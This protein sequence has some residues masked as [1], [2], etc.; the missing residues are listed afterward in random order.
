MTK[1]RSRLLQALERLAPASAGD[2]AR[3]L[4]LSA[5]DVRRHLA[6]LRSER[7]VEEAGLRPSDGRGRPVRLFRLS[8][9]LTGQNLDLLADLAL[10]LWLDG[11]TPAAR[12]SALRT[13]ARRLVGPPGGSAPLDARRLAAV[14]ER[15]NRLHYRARW[16]ARPDGPRVFFDHC[17]YAALIER[18]P[19]LCRMDAFLLEN[20]LGQ[21]VEQV[22]R[23]ARSVRGG[24]CC[25]FRMIPK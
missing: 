3:P 23:L 19:E 5:S 12:D 6:I 25:S 1:T 24:T 14:V 15:L 21:P 4:G 17:P 20:Q 7:L 2:L 16:E 13:L 18:H 11:L 9:V 22:E 10:D 8:P